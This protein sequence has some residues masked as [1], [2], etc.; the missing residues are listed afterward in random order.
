MVL[1]VREGCMLGERTRLAKRD[2]KRRAPREK[3]PT[4]HSSENQMVGSNPT[5]GDK[6]DP[7]VKE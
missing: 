2:R 7:R 1:V 4:S 3:A 6:R 5:I